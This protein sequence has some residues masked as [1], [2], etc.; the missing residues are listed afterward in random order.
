MHYHIN[1]IL[2]ELDAEEPTDRD[3]IYI[4]AKDEEEFNNALNKMYNF[5]TGKLQF[6]GVMDTPTEIVVEKDVREKYRKFNED[7]F[8]MK[9]QPQED[10]K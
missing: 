7:Q 8:L 9:E 10:S 5:S 4:D 2:N 1:E 6:T 3:C